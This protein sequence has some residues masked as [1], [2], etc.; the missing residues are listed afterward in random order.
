[1]T[2]QLAR[3]MVRAGVKTFF[4]GLEN[5]DPA[6]QRSTGGKV[7]AGELAA[8][9]R[10]LRAAGAGFIG[11]YIIVGHP[12]SETR[13][14]E[15]S[16]RFAHECGTRVF[17]SEFSPV[18]GTVDGAKSDAWADLAEPL[19]HNK[20]SFTIRR[21]GPDCLNKLKALTRELNSRLGNTE[22]QPSGSASPWDRIKTI[23]RPAP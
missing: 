5:S 15:E 8:A 1:M 16:I 13:Q 18:P 19:S 4:F 20:T 21:M 3:L 14:L 22:P 11:T 17:L 2:E 10:L 7:Y 23:R 6:W 9:V 12:D